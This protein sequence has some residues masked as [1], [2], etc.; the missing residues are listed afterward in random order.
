MLE[1]L[2]HSRSTPGTANPIAGLADASGF[3]PTISYTSRATDFRHADWPVS[4][5][6]VDWRLGRCRR[7]V[8]PILSVFVDAVV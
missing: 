3:T 1:F 4:I 7:A 2:L 8:A 5:L 6:V